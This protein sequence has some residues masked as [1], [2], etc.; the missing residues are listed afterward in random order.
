MVLSLLPDL[1]RAWQVSVVGAFSAFLIVGY[2]IGGSIV[3]IIDTNSDS[4]DMPTVYEQPLSATEDPVF[5]FTLMSSFGSIMFGYGFHA[6]LPDIQAS[7]HDHNTK[8]SKSD[9][10]KAVTAAFSFSYPAYIIVALI[11]FAAFG[12]SVESDVLLSINNVL[13][14]DAMYVIWIF[15]TIKTS[16]E[17]AVYNQAAFTLTRDITG[18]TIDSDHSDHHPR[19]WKIDFVMRFVYV[20]A[21][22]CIAVFIPF[23]SSLISY[24]II[25]RSSLKTY[26]YIFELL[27]Y[28]V[29]L[30]ILF[31]ALSFSLSLSVVIILIIQFTIE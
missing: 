13:S 2:C 5:N 7:L 1:N 9:M 25:Y 12:Y 26:T 11:G 21:A 4:S 31:T 22:A 17:A 15:V 23:V 30:P 28:L 8:D 16:T 29:S 14:K 19:N 6:V 18:L 27:M 20:T 3:A 24:S 10:K